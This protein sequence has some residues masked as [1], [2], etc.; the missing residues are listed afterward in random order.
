MKTLLL[1]IFF[2]LI[3]ACGQA[4]DLPSKT[5]VSLHQ[6]VNRAQERGLNFLLQKQ[7][8]NGAWGHGHPAITAL[9]VTAFLRSGNELTADQ[10]AAAARGLAFIMSNVKTNGAIYGGGEADK[11]PN[12]STAI[13]IAA[14]VAAKDA[15]Y[16]ETIRNA[17]QFLLESQSDEGEQIGPANQ[18]Y[19]GIGYGRRGRPDLSNSSWAYEALKLSESIADD[20]PLTANDLHWKKAVAFITRCQNLPKHN[21][22]AWAEKTSPDD[23]GGFVY[24]PDFS[25][26][27]EEQVET[28]EGPLRSHGSISYAG[29][30]S[31][32]YADL[33]KDDPRVKAVISWLA[34]HY[35]LD[36]N[37]GM[38]QQGLYYYLH[39]MTKALTAYGEDTFRTTDG[40]Q[41]DWRYELMRKFVQLQRADG[42][43]Q[44]DN[45]RFWE[46]DP[47]LVTTYSVLSLEILQQR[48]YL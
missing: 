47:V 39:L 44:N 27:N 30:K 5:E 22:Q 14:L 17:R 15:K 25:F 29:L 7:E 24:M 35:T 21:D 19:G 1:M 43:W 36:E 20:S 10:R 26:V 41:H 4:V 46:N 28:Q 38:G 11:Y 37:P 13:C 12:Y 3:A 6:E 8:P 48:K 33:K 34:G 16:F 2:A 9:A 31:Y 45:N 23:L 32:M 18:S 42:N 40:K